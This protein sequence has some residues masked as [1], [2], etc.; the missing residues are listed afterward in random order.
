MELLNKFLDYLLL[1]KGSP[2]NTIIAYKTDINKFIK[3][4]SSINVE[5]KNVKEEDI[6]NFIKYMRKRKFNPNSIS[7]AISSIKVFYKFLLQENIINYSV[8]KNIKTP[9]I[10]KKLPD[11][12]SP[13]EI[14]KIISQANELTPI[15]IRDK[16][17]LELLYACG[18]RISELINIKLSDV[19][20]EDQFIRCVGK[21]S[22]ERIVPFGKYAKEALT[23][24]LMEARSLIKKNK[25]SEFLFLNAKG[26]KLS[27]M[28]A[29]KIITHYV[30]KSGINKKI[31][32]HTFRHSF[33]THLL[34]G[35]ADLRIVQELLGHSSITTTEIYTHIDR[36][37][38][39]EAIR[40]Y[41]PRG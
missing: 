2:Q 25:S 23:Y 21:G 22:K 38:L 27:R 39:R 29:W 20:I 35:G 7:R 37:R 28:G 33:A 14:Q 30:I 40:V 12:L 26:G 32:P 10:I 17:I 15:G 24:Y 41:H 19:F 3:F 13:D 18:L 8:V 6:E 11:V 34:E 5:I 31:T 16:A 36:E 1:E 4:L 9:K